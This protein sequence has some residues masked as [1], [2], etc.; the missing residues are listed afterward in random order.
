MFYK[1][2]LFDIEFMNIKSVFDMLPVIISV[3]PLKG[4]KQN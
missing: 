2:K 4:E 3:R 1:P